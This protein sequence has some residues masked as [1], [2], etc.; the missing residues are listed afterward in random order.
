MALAKLINTEQTWRYE[1]WRGRLALLFSVLFPD[2]RPSSLLSDWKVYL[3]LFSREPKI[4]DLL[5]SLWFLPQSSE[6]RCLTLGFRE[7]L[8]PTFEL[9]VDAHVDSTLSVFVMEFYCYSTFVRTGI[10]QKLSLSAAPE[11]GL[12]SM[13]TVTDPSACRSIYRE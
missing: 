5:R 7:K 10:H 3:H 4:G 11:D 8:L 13:P 6:Q 12:A 1:L 2:Q 9:W